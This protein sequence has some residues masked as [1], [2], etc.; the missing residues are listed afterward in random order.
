MCKCHANLKY[1]SNSRWLF[2]RLDRLTLPWQ[3]IWQISLFDWA[4][5]ANTHHPKDGAAVVEFVTTPNNPCDSLRNVVAVGAVAKQ[6]RKLMVHD[7]SYTGLVTKD[8]RH[9]SLITRPV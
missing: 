7:M 2:L 6:R 1:S 5:D 8:T 4:G 9:S 3:S